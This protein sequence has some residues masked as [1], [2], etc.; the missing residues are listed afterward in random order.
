MHVRL[1]VFELYDAV[2]F[3]RLRGGRF[4][5]LPP[6]LKPEAASLGTHKF[7]VCPDSIDTASKLKY[8]SNTAVIL[9]LS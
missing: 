6:D 9:D 7:R 4:G 5:R 2:A 8:C 3:C 1:Q